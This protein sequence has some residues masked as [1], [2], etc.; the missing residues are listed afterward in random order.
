MADRRPRGREGV[1]YRPFL[2]RLATRWRLG[3]FALNDG[4]GVI[5]EVEGDP[6]V[7]GLFMGELV[8][9]AP[10]H[11]SVEELAASKVPVRGEREFRIEPS[12]GGASRRVRSAH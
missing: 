12:A 2:H 5:V 7:L 3:G 11:A 6:V 8:D 1:R 4:T 9:D 10:P